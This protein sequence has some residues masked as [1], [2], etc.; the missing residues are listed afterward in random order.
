MAD[1]SLVSVTSLPS[2]PT[3]SSSESFHHVEDLQSLDPT[4]ATTSHDDDVSLDIGGGLDEQEEELS[5]EQLRERYDDEEIDRFLHL[6]SAVRLSRRRL[7][8][9]HPSR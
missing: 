4:V 6:F 9:T 2:S 8:A 5:E 7:F 3:L 1:E